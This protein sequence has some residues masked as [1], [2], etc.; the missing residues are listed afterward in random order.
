M[1]LNAFIGGVDSLRNEVTILVFALSENRTFRCIQSIGGTVL[2]E[3]LAS[4]IFHFVC[5]KGNLAAFCCIRLR[6]VPVVPLTGV[7]HLVGQDIALVVADVVRLAEDVV[8]IYFLVIGILDGLIVSIG[9]G[10]SCTLVSNELRIGHD[11]GACSIFHTVYLTGN[12]VRIGLLYEQILFI[13]A[14]QIPIPVADGV[15][16]VVCLAID[17]H[18]LAIAQFYARL[19]IVGIE[20]GHHVQKFHLTMRGSGNCQRNLYD[21]AIGIRLAG[22]G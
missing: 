1:A 8:I 14:Q 9:I 16:L 22:V 12:T 20:A 15:V 5:S 7:I 19:C 18:L 4:N 2:I 13:V 10:M 3:C 17:N 11:V 21:F 6:C